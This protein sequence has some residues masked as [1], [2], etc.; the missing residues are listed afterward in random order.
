MCYTTYSK[1]KQH[2]LHTLYKKEYTMQN[3]EKVLRYIN[4]NACG[5]TTAQI[6]GACNIAQSTAL[7][8]ANKLAK[9]EEVTMCSF[10]QANFKHAYCNYYFPM[11]KMKDPC[12][13]AHTVA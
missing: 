7:R 8:I 12:C 9:A 6:A 10:P 5:V 11:G 1:T 4:A 2:T 3:T 13:V